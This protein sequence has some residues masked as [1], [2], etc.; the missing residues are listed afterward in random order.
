MKVREHQRQLHKARTLG[1]QVNSNQLLTRS[2]LHFIRIVQGLIEY[3]AA[4]KTGTVTVYILQCMRDQLHDV[5]LDHGMLPCMCL[6]KM[7]AQLRWLEI[8]ATEVAVPAQGVQKQ[9]I[10]PDCGQVISLE[11]LFKDSPQIDRDV[12]WHLAG[13]FSSRKWLGHQDGI[14]NAAQLHGKLPIWQAYMGHTLG[15][16]AGIAN[17]AKSPHIRF[18]Q[19]KCM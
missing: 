19:L 4:C 9:S 6:V 8:K 15:I 17:A 2:F 14:R 5:S 3:L 18:H 7:V 11:S 12:G 16:A 13:K 10:R 1:A